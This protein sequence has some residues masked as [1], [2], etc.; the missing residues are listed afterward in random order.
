MENN[1]KK[2]SSQDLPVCPHDEFCGGCVYQ[3]VSYG[4]QLANKEGEA[5]GFF[6]ERNIDVGKW[7]A[8]EGCPDE[9][10]YR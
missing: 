3:G 4:D 5:R 7:D 8:I 6:S 10:R 2:F 9:S 1:N